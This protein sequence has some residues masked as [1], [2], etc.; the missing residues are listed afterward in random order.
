M[1][2][3]IKVPTDDDADS[4]TGVFNH[5]SRLSMG[6]LGAG[7]AVDLGQHVASAKFATDGHL[8]IVYAIVNQ[9]AIVLFPTPI[10]SFFLTT[11]T[12]LLSDSCT[13]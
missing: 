8:I 6:H 13:S 2:A 11:Q 9:S 3:K 4:G 5:F 12:F 10:V 7:T 1:E